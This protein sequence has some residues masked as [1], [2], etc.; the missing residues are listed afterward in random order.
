VDA[1]ALAAPT[2]VERSGANSKGHP[3]VT[4][5]Y[6][7]NLLQHSD[8]DTVQVAREPQPYP[9]APQAQHQAYA[10]SAPQPAQQVVQ[11]VPQQMPVQ[12]APQ[13]QP[14]YVQA[15]PAQ[16]RSGGG[17]SVVMLALIVVLVG[18]VAVVGG[19]YAT[20]QASPSALE[21]NTQ[22]G[23]ASDSAYFEGQ[24]R[25]RD[26]G[27]T[28]A[29]SLGGTTARLNA[30]LARETA[31]NKAYQQGI[32]AGNKIPRSTGR[33]YGGTRRSSGIRYSGPSETFQALGQA[34]SL[35][36]AT[37]APVDVEIY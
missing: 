36:N 18:A 19:Y 23:L 1:F 16:R 28:A 3:A 2:P 4:S 15:A 31:Y 24:A 9:Y 13:Q 20:R 27:R 26:A 17:L 6:S 10:Q 33:Y 12:Y 14:V 32:T 29:Q 34:Q 35:A 37:G 8:D 5:P 7:S 30:A 25:G 22:V 21:A 11:Y